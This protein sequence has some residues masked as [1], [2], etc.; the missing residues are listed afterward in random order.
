MV[1]GG[2]CEMGGTPGGGG[3]LRSALALGVRGQ[4]G[5]GRDGLGGG[6]LCALASPHF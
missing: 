6:G 4:Q 3:G 1:A 5:E 2:S